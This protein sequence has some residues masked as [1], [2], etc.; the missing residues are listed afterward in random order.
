M[1]MLSSLLLSMVAGQDDKLLPPADV[2]I[3]KRASYSDTLPSVDN[4]HDFTVVEDATKRKTSKP[5][6]GDRNALLNDID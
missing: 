2:S 6:F 1:Q 5:G 4:E 3:E